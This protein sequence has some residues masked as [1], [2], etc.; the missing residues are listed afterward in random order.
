M[1]KVLVGVVK[2]GATRQR[3]NARCTMHRD[4]DKLDW[5]CTKESVYEDI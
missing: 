1:E 2:P 4:A 5:T 3:E